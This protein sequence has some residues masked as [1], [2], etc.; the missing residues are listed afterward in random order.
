M[1][2]VPCLPENAPF[3]PE[4]RA[5]MNG[6]LAGLFSN[7]NA[8]TN[9]DSAASSSTKPRASVLVAFGSQ[10]GSAQGLAKKLAREA[11]QRGFSPSVKELNA[12]TPADLEKE[13]RCVIV[14]ST[15]GDG[16]PPDNAVHFWTQ[17][18]A[19][20]APRL[21]KLSFAVLGLGDR[22]YPEFCGASKKFDERLA[23]LGAKRLAP[24]GECDVDYEAAAKAWTESLWTVLA[25]AEAPGSESTPA[26]PPTAAVAATTLAPGGGSS[27]AGHSRAN[28]FAARLKTNRRLNAAGSQKDTRHFEIALHGSGL[29][30]EAGDAL[31]VV[32]SNCPALVE[33][34]LA[35]LGFTGDETVEPGSDGDGGNLHRILSSRRVI[36][37]PPPGLI[38][39]A[40]TRAGNA[41]LLA[42]LDPARKTDLDPWLYGRDVVDVLKACPGAAF[43]PAELVAHLRKLQPRLYSI[44][45]SPKAHPDEVHLTVAAVRYEAHGRTRKGVCSG[46]LADHVALDETPVPVFVQ[47]SHGFRL[48]VD[49]TTPV[50]MIGPGTAPFRA[51]LEER[52]ALGATGRNWLFFGDQQRDCDFLYEQELTAWAADGFL[53]RLDLAFSRDQAEKIYVQTR[54]SEQASGLWSWLEDGAHL[55]VCG[56]ARRMAKDV[57]AALHALIGSAGGRTPEQAIEYVA[58]LKASKRYQRDV[59]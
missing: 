59:Y 46:W 39:D 27:A 54:M 55:Y 42:L 57:D 6:F 58:A 4:Q 51:F 29:R 50:I 5:W 18:S 28:P 53:T 47:T 48:P 41:D 12:V 26:G 35:A 8:N 13:S 32:P 15:W 16:D 14:T 25:S 43:A 45:S 23:A 21:E 7:A 17:I 30:Y 44:S 3:T 34:L 11:E 9:A 56:D 49:P 24:R 2:P 22:N 1:N 20:T 19:D 33:E 31:G 40:A 38:R 52:R 37:A 10:T 36:T